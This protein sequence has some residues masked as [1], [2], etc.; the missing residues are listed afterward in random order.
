[1]KL[2]DPNTKVV[3]SKFHSVPFLFGNQKYLSGYG[4]RLKK[5]F[6]K[7]KTNFSLIGHDSPNASIS[8]V[9]PN[10]IK[11]FIKIIC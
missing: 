7:L 5:K 3:S 6:E 2:I 9:L 10:T 1:M 8:R 11:D 4:D